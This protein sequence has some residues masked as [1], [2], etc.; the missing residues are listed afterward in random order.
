[1]QNIYKNIASLL[2]TL[3]AYYSLLEWQIFQA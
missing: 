1:M 3:P 2:K